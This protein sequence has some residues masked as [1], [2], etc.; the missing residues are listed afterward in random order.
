KLDL[1]DVLDV[2]APVDKDA[3][4]SIAGNNQ[5]PPLL[6]PAKITLQAVPT[7]SAVVGAAGAVADSDTPI[8][9][10]ATN[11]AA[12]NVY[13]ATA[14]ANGWAYAAGE[15]LAMFNLADP[16][17][18][19]IAASSNQPGDESAIALA[20]GYAFTGEYYYYN[21]GRIHVYDISTPGAAPRYIRTQAMLGG[22]IS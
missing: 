1:V 4:S 11:T 16:A 12:S 6:N 8:T 9:L 14:A 7:G 18:L 21:D 22:G 5:A 3:A 20:G 2:A 13:P 15:H 19:P 17:A 10:F